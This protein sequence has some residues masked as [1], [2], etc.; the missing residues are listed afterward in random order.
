MRAA[1][2]VAEHPAHAATAGR[3]C[4]RA[5]KESVRLKRRVQHIPDDARLRADPTFSGIDLQDAVEVPGDV[6]DDAVADHLAR[7]GSPP[8]PRNEVRPLPRGQ[9]DQILDILHRLGIGDALRDLPVGARIRRICDLVQA[10]GVNLH[11]RC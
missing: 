10:V 7:N 6:H 1:G 2:V 9:G 11:A 3:G 4:L 8:G 5:E